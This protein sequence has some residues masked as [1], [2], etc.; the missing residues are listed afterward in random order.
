MS[1]RASWSAAS[2]KTG[3]FKVTSACVGRLAAVAFHDA[4]GAGGASRSSMVGCKAMR[5]Q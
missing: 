2:T 3:A 5:R 1:R 4:H